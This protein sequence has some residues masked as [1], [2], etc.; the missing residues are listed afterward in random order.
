MRELNENKKNH[1]L[2]IGSFVILFITL[3]PLIRLS[4]YNHPCLWDDYNVFWGNRIRQSFSFFYGSRYATQFLTPYIFFPSLKNGN[5]ELFLTLI[6]EYHLFSLIYVLLFTIS[7]LFFISQINKNIIHLEK[8]S[9]I[10]LFSI[11]LFTIINFINA[12][13]EMFYCHTVTTG[14]TGGVIF[15]FFFLGL[16]IKYYYANQS[17]ER[18]FTAILLFLVTFILS[19][20]IEFFVIFAGY[21]SFYLFLFVKSRNTNKRINLFFFLFVFSLLIFASFFIANYSKTGEQLIEAKYSGEGSSLIGRIPRWCSTTLDFIKQEIK[22]ILYP[23]NFLVIIFFCYLLHHK[24]HIKPTLKQ[25]FFFLFLYP[26][27][28]IMS[29]SGCYGGLDWFSLYSYPRNV[30]DVVFFL[31]SMPLMYMIYSFV[32]DNFIIKDTVYSKKIKYAFFTLAGLS[33][34]ITGIFSSRYLLGT[35]W[36]DLLSGKAKKYNEIQLQ[37][38]TDIFSN[39]DK[40]I[41]DVKYPGY[42]K[43]IVSLQGNVFYFSKDTNEIIAREEMLRFFEYD[44]INYL[45]DFNNINDI[46]YDIKYFF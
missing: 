11:S 3:F 19:G 23:T 14:Y 6:N 25:F 8:H 12:S 36:N 26:V 40:K 32:M 9:F 5:Y 35:A 20:F 31:V 10:F 2:L 45:Y 39:Q 17:K 13:A 15:M 4:F 7:Y 44:K 33:I 21:V 18:I 28:L 1:L 34:L 22:K 30:F 29:F 24:F 38:Y 37:N 27:I 41:L 46:P 42:P 16:I 43:S